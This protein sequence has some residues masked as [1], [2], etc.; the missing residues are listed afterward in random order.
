[1]DTKTFAQFL[2]VATVILVGWWAASYMLFRPGQQAPALQP[3]PVVAQEGA[4]PVRQPDAEFAPVPSQAPDAAVGV[5]APDGPAVDLRDGIVLENGLIRTYWTNRGAALQRLEL[6]SENYR[7]PYWEGDE[8]PVLT[9]LRDFQDDL[10][11][12][13]LCRVTF[14]SGS[15]V[16]EQDP[17]QIN[18]EVVE[19]ADDR[20]VF[21]TVL[22]DG[23][24]RRMRVRKTVTL[25][26]DRYDY[27]VVLEFEN[28]S[29]ETFEFSC[30]LR[31]AAGIQ[32]EA[33]E[34]TYLGTRVGIRKRANSY[35]VTKTRG[36]SLARKGPIVNE[37]TMIVW[38]GVVNHYFIAVTHPENREWI[39]R[40]E[41]Q[42]VR[43]DDLWHA[44]GRW[45]PGTVRR[46]AD[47]PKLANQNATVV[48]HTTREKLQP[49]V[50]LTRRYT[51]IAAP[52]ERELLK[53]YDAGLSKLIEFGMLPS[54]SRLAIGVLNA[55]RAVIPNYGIAILIL[56]V[57]VRV[58]LHPL[59][60]KSQLSLMK[61]QKLQ[62]QMQELQQK[63][64]DDRQKL[65]Q[66]QM[67]LYR[68]YGAHPLSG[69]GP[70]MLQMP[71]FIALF[72]ALRAA[73]ELRHAGFLWVDDLSRPDTLFHL[74]FYLPLLGNEVNLLPMLMAA[75]MMVN[76]KFTAQPATEQARQQQKMMKWFPLIFVVM[77]YHMPS[78][79]CLYWTTS[80]CIGLL[81]RW[82]IEKRSDKMELK[83]IS[84]KPTSAKKRPGRPKQPKK[85][86]WMEKLQKM[87]EGDPRARRSPN[88]R[89]KP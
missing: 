80:T 12:D 82:L 57:L 6:L 34:T 76:Q 46:E 61:M 38:A 16:Q 54:V 49:G 88:K 45:G 26:P 3:A 74:P 4:A 86:G 70:M 42:L 41:S 15:I 30:G 40:V 10:L 5:E 24:G 2:L 64:A 66:E 7:A 27:D 23:A 68:R 85:G 67:E 48:I 75:A 31:G 22:H 87:T 51:F 53:A 79:L 59:T 47:R 81:E 89:K 44:R 21:E 63:Y 72:S 50:P 33:I 58:V 69:C 8:R 17:S 35:D 71:V 32:R 18:Y 65:A 9:L 43:D 29:Q 36:A 13:T 83:P 37:S 39:D 77:L 19:Q 55:V 11:S 73:I 20:L 52:K 62:P 84:Q 78:G 1:M 14:A 25:A 28:L 60:R 56:T